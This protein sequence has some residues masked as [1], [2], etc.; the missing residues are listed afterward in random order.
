MEVWAW[1]RNRPCLASILRRNLGFVR[2]EP[3]KERRLLLRID[4]YGKEQ[5]K[6]ISE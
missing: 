4:R 6:I 3:S 2:I 1:E 5:G